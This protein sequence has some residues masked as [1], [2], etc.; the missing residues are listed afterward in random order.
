MKFSQTQKLIFAL[1][2]LAISGF[3]I[4]NTFFATSPIGVGS[5]VDSTATT[6]IGSE[7]QDIIDMANKIK[8]VSIDS[9]LFSSPLF[10]SL[11]DFDVP[12]TPEPQGRPNPFANIGTDVG[13]GTFLVASSSKSVK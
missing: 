6:T 3:I 13:G 7:G 12:S 8:T 10:T 4:Y 2:I 1:V 9:G 5:F 11:V